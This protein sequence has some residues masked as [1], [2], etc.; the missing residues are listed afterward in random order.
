MRYYDLL[1]FLNLSKFTTDTTMSKHIKTC[2]NIDIIEVD[3]P[4]NRGTNIS[5]KISD[6]SITITKF[7][8]N[9][10]SE[11]TLNKICVPKIFSINIKNGTKDRILKNIILSASVF[12]CI[13]KTMEGAKIATE[14]QL[15]PIRVPHSTPTLLMILYASFV[16][17]LLKSRLILG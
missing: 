13:N 15:R 1:K 2:D 14:M 17:F 12:P 9:I 3:S 4:L 8:K 16:S 10:L 11:P 5:E 6:T 7:L